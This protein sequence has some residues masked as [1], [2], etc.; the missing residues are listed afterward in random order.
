[1]QGLPEAASASIIVLSLYILTDHSGSLRGS[2]SAGLSVTV[3]YLVYIPAVLYAVYTWFALV[4][5]EIDLSSKKVEYIGSPVSVLAYTIIPGI[6]GVVYLIFGPVRYAIKSAGGEAG[7]AVYPLFI[8]PE[9]YTTA[10]KIVRY[11][12]YYYFDFWWFVRGFDKEKNIL[13]TIKPLIDNRPVFLACWIGAT[14]ILTIIIFTGLLKLIKRRDKIDNYIIGW[15]VIYFIVDTYMNL[16]WVGGFQFRHFFPVFPAIAFVFGVGAKQVA[17]LL[18]HKMKSFDGLNHVN[19]PLKIGMKR[20]LQIVLLLSF[21]FMISATTVGGLSTGSYTKVS[22]IDP[23]TK[24][25]NEVSTDDKIAVTSSHAYRLTYLFSEGKV[26]PTV[27]ISKRTASERLSS[28]STKLVPRTVTANATIISPQNISRID[29]DYLFVLP[30]CEYTVREQQLIQTSLSN[31]GTIVY[32]MTKK[33]GS[34]CDTRSILIR[35]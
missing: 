16:G 2:L 8:T 11:I 3:A 18:C 7:S 10:E 28:N 1:M 25:T 26:K 32:N 30:R 22:D 4:V 19:M 23:V 20:G 29:A 5:S 31:G 27:L 21:I 34:R 15:V 9:S 17:E 24:L 12:S 6:V 33:Q 14:F 13:A 35:I